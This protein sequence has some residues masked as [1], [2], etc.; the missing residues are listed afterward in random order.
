MKTLIIIPIKNAYKKILQTVEDIVNLG[1]HVDYIVID[2]GSTD[3]TKHLL[4]NNSIQ[5]LKFPIESTYGEAISLGMTYAKEKNYDA[6]IEWNQDGRFSIKNINYLIRTFEAQKVDIVL[7]SRFHEEK[8][9]YWNWKRKLLSRAIRLVSHKK[10][11]DPDLKLKLIG[12]RAFIQL[13]DMKYLY[14]GPDAICQLLKARYSFKEIQ[15]EVD[16]KIKRI[17]DKGIIYILQNILL[18]VFSN[19][20]KRKGK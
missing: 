1:E 9:S 2:Y 8:A 3:N 19:P 18:M 5:Y 12:K 14:S 17:P 16:R 10:V 4:Q 13:V 20:I 11:S 6:I 7:S 15:V